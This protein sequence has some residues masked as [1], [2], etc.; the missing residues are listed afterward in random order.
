MKE[1]TYDKQKNLEYV[2]KLRELQNELPTFLRSFFIGIDQTTA[3]RTRVAY[4]TDLKIF[5]EYLM[6]YNPAYKNIKVNE[7]PLDVLTDLTAQDFEEFIQY[8]KLYDK[9]DGKIISNTERGIK[10]KL[11]SLRAMYHYYHK[12]K[13]IAE[14]PIL[15]V[16]MP[17]LHD[18]AIIRLD[19][20]EIARFLDQIES[21]DKLSKKQQEYHEKTKVRDLA[22]ITLFLGTGIRVSECVGLDL[23]D[24]DLNN[25]RIKVV[26]KGGYEDFVYFG[27]EVRSALLSYLD[28]RE[29]IIAIQNHENALF[30]SSRRQRLSVRSVEVLVK[31]YAQLVTYN[32][33]ITPHKLR[34]TY[35]TAL[36]RETN[37][38]YLVADVLGHKDVNTTKKHYAALEEERKR[39]A[40]NAVKLRDE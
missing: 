33:K 5:F 25:D 11:S 23:M 8:L 17:K 24:V 6:S 21:G 14:N 36:Y 34:S 31:K 13:M 2:K 12:N 26:R 4:A 27:E 30:L 3:P 9:P 20:D 7:I 16:D 22:L 10:R 37:D 38:I 1:I 29:N 40:R 15:Q 32:K 19:T 35:G 28:E 39:S 18:K